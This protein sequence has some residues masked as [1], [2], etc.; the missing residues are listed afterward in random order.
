MVALV[1]VLE[2]ICENSKYLGNQ[3]FV[4]MLPL[5]LTNLSNGQRSGQSGQHKSCSS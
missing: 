5:G 3:V 1:W 4:S 2:M